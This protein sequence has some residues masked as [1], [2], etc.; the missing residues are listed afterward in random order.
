MP[1]PLQLLYVRSREKC[2]DGEQQQNTHFATPQ[3]TLPHPA[4]RL[5][6]A[7]HQHRNMPQPLQLLSKPKTLT[8]QLR[9][10]L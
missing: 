4:L 3:A 8:K 6:T 7:V 2:D 5:C 10:L 1:Q 9:R